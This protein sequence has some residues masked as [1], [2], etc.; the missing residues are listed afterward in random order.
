M[1][2]KC[3]FLKVKSNKKIHIIKLFLVHFLNE[4]T[5]GVLTCT[6]IYFY[7]PHLT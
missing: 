7:D 4:E 6:V 3:N 2:R 1:F 5:E